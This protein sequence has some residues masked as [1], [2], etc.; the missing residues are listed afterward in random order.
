M[1]FVSTLRREIGH[2]LDGTD[3][4]L[5][6]SAFNSGIVAIFLYIIMFITSGDGRVVSVS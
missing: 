1:I 2:K 5:S 6:G 3:G 4:S